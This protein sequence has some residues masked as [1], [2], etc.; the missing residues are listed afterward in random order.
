MGM[1]VATLAFINTRI[2]LLAYHTV[3]VLDRFLN[4]LSLENDLGVLKFP[5]SI[6]Q[7]AKYMSVV[8]L[9]HGK[10]QKPSWTAKLA[11][12]YTGTFVLVVFW[13]ETGFA[14]PLCFW[15]VTVFVVPDVALCA[16]WEGIV[17]FMV[18]AETSSTGS[19]ENPSG[20]FATFLQLSLPYVLVKVS[21]LSD[22]LRVSSS[23]NIFSIVKFFEMVKVVD[24]LILE[25]ELYVFFDEERYVVVLYFW[26]W[27]GFRLVKGPVFDFLQFLV[28][29]YFCVIEVTHQNNYLH[30]NFVQPFFF[31]RFLIVCLVFLLHLIQYILPKSEHVHLLLVDFDCL[32]NVAL[33]IHYQNI[34]FLLVCLVLQNRKIIIFIPT[35]FFNQTQVLV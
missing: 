13:E 21:F 27:L 34:I 28:Q 23:R 30:I 19:L 9:I 33:S 7:H 22:W 12:A 24:I 10:V 15:N 17:K 4:V 3:N 25:C 18:I 11:F 2:R 31:L 6:N 26:R 20:L 1:I 29:L 16:E 14:D 32:H 8:W 5:Q 35:E